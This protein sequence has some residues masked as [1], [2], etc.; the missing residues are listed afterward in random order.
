MKRQSNRFIVFVVL[1]SLIFSGSAF[2]AE[3]HQSFFRCS[4]HQLG[5]GVHDVL[6]S[7]V[8]VPRYTYKEFELNGPVAASFSGVVEG[9]GYMIKRL[10]VGVYETGT[11]YIRQKPILDP[12][13]FTSDSF[14]ADK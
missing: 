13:F 10:G 1:I 14:H 9:I 5:R 7:W 3:Q 2:A 6:L 8:E 11:F 12:E 4:L